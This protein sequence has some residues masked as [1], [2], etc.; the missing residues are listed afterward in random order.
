MFW[1]FQFPLPSSPLLL[2]S[3]SSNPI[4]KNHFLY[5][6]YNTEFLRCSIA[7]QCNSWLVS[8]QDKG[9]LWDIKEIVM[10]NEAD[11][12]SGEWNLLDDKITT[13]FTRLTREV[14]RLPPCSLHYLACS[15][16]WKKIIIDSMHF[17]VCVG[18][19]TAFFPCLIS[20]MEIKCIFFVHVSSFCWW[21]QSATTLVSMHILEIK[22]ASCA[23]ECK[24]T[25][26]LRI[27]TINELIYRHQH[28]RSALSPS[29]CRLSS[30]VD[31][32]WLF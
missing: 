19:E 22:A 14:C 12:S 4:F 20:A 6:I 2:T 1:I 17:Y 18:G 29:W 28:K 15:N 31:E 13:L 26:D 11:L 5:E 16:M 21:F 25:R 10:W 23:P 30:A 27:L 9:I 8:E 7:W 32:I 3:I 24:A